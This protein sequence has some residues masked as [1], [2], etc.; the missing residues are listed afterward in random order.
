MCILFS[1]WPGMTFIGHAITELIVKEIGKPCIISGHSS[2]GILAAYIA[3][4]IPRY[5]QGLLLEDPPFFNVEP[6]EFE[7]T[8]VYKDGFVVT[9]NFMNQNEEKEFLAYYIE[10]GYIFNYLG[11]RYFGKDWTHKL[12]LEAKEKLIE[13]PCTIPKLTKVPE[14]S[15]HG[16]TYMNRF[17]DAFSESFY[18]GEWFEGVNQEEILKKSAVL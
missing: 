14:N 1:I 5:V 13:Q 3:E 12:A 17:D 4:K 10:N 11:N 18:T 9:H 2:G 6:G 15:F 16:F 7:N 8:F